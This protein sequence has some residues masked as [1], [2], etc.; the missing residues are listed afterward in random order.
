MKANK[1]M[2]NDL[3]LWI[4]NKNSIDSNKHPLHNLRTP[5]S[6]AENITLRNIPYKQLKE[7]TAKLTSQQKEE[8]YQ[9]PIS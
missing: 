6:D 3:F 2:M 7:L 4:P 8:E 1:K 5:A 9:Q